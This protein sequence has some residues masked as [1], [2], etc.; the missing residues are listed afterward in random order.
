[1]VAIYTYTYTYTYKGI[2]YHSLED[3]GNQLAKRCSLFVIFLI[4]FL[5]SLTTTQENQLLATQKLRVRLPFS[6]SDTDISCMIKF[7]HF[8]TLS[9]CMYFFF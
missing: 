8:F 5:R 1:M 3:T 7:P 6:Q 2:I 9:A 4:L